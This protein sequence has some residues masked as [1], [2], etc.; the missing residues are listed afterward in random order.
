MRLARGGSDKELVVA[1]NAQ[2]PSCAHVQR[3]KGEAVNT[4]ESASGKALEGVRV[5]DLTQWEA[6]GSVTQALAWYGADVVK[7]E[8]PIRGE[9]GRPASTDIPGVDSHY[10]IMLNC[11]KRSV[12]LNL[13]DERG[14]QLLRD[15]IPKADIFVENF[16]P[17]TIERL[18]FSYEEVSAIN[19]RIIYAQVKGYGPET[20]WA[21]YLALD[22]CAQ[23]MGGALSITGTPETPPLKPG[24]T[25]ADT[26]SG[27]HCLSGILAALYQRCRTGRGQR[28]QVAMQDAVVNMCRI[29]YVAQYLL[30]RAAPR[31]GNKSLIATTAPADNYPC[32]PFGPNDYCYIYASR[33]GS[34][35]WKRLLR[36]VGRED[37]LGDPRFESP[38]A[39]AA[40]EKQVDEVIGEWT[41]RH[42]KH[43]VLRILGTAGVPAGA[44]M[45]TKE[46]SQDPDLRKRGT[47]VT[48]Q[49]PV[50][51]EMV[52][53]G[54]PVKMSDSPVEVTTAPVLGAHSDE[55]Y[56]E[57]LGLEKQQI[58]QLRVARII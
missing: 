54:W 10:F 7:I 47:F 4:T 51:G 5:L 3:S 6:G 8:E 55:V 48:I 28:I 50:R 56:R 41:R 39:R 58:E 35:H 32:K 2:K 45:D 16:A 22:M 46:L 52:V 23:A 1:L 29:S 30:G 21:G 14:K 19:P 11:N 9:A 26:G 20:P 57:W 34:R 43:E 24:P 36:A 25:M 42:T 53:P 13:R 17:G 49:H 18:G 37:L 15:M 44:V 27:L 40:N 31:V 33:G 12:T 38:E